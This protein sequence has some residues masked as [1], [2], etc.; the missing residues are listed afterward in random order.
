MV[1]LYAAVLVIWGN[2][3]SA[4]LA[5]SARLPAGSWAFVMSGA[6]LVGASLLFARAVDL[7]RDALGLRSN[8]VPGAAIGAAAGAVVALVGVAL[9]RYLAPAIVGVQVDYAPLAQVTSTDLGA[10]I[11]FFLPLGAVIPEELA[12]RGVLLGALVRRGG[13]RT[14]A[15]SSA[16]A[17]ALWHGAVVAAT[18]GDTTIGPPSPWFVPAVLAGLLVVFGGGVVFALM[19]L[20]TATL[21]STTAAH[22]AFNALVLLGLWYTRPIPNL[23]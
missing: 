19:R 14:A 7:D 4:L 20:R 11:A 17:F 9:L 5:S 8:A 21:A 10:H 6:A 16:G 22:W 15:V 18:I 12:F 3:A 1:W 13:V 2:L 23:G